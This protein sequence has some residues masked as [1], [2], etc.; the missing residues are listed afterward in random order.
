M[1][2]EY[3]LLWLP[4][5]AV[6]LLSALAAINWIGVKVAAFLAWMRRWGER[7]RRVFLDWE[8]E[9]GDDGHEPRPGV[10]ARLRSYDDKIDGVTE[11]L[12]EFILVQQSHTDQ[13]E[14]NERSIKLATLETARA[15]ESARKNSEAITE[16]AEAVAEIR[17]HVQPNHGTSAYDHMLKEVKFLSGQFAE[18]IGMMAHLSGDV[19]RLDSIVKRHHPQ[20]DP[21]AFS[22]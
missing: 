21:N 5:G 10:M 12:R 19:E 14:F 6:G 1:P 2:P 18:M 17:H 3:V 9:P 15:A 13:L 7:I 16:V 22:D 4:A 11:G 8:G 20:Y